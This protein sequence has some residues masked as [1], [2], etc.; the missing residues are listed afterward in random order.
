MP[1]IAITTCTYNPDPQIFSQV[2]DSFVRLKIPK[3]IVVEGVI[4]DNNSNPPLDSFEYIRKF[5]KS[6]PWFR[7]IVESKQGK[8]NAVIKGVLETS[9]EILINFDDDNVPNENYLINLMRLIKN[10]PQVSVW[11]PGVVKVLF[12]GEVEEWV[13]KFAIGFFQEK[14]TK[15]NKIACSIYADSN[16]I[17]T[18]MVIKRNIM[19]IYVDNFLSGKYTNLCRYGNSLSTGGDLQIVLTA[20]KN[21]WS[22]GSSPELQVDHII[23]VKRTSI[24]YIS[25]LIYGY[26]SSEH[27]AV[28]EVFPEE[29]D[30]VKLPDMNVA[31]ISI[32]K[33]L[34]HIPGRYYSMIQYRMDVADTLGKISG[35]YKVHKLQEPLWVRILIKCLNLK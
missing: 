5:L 22:C 32:V 12:S 14:S 26:G 4:V 16:P 6:C 15:E 33:K 11:G 19:K 31:F 17:G 27:E 24:F 20:I 8:S 30:K 7:L 10:Y 3:G 25:K 35:A 1:D 18:G 28:I 13:S 21:G 34:F 29:I 2:L 23:P 9:S